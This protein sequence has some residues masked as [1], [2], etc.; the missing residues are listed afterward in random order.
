MRKAWLSYPERRAVNLG[1]SY[2]ALRERAS[3]FLARVRLHVAEFADL[4]T[5]F[6]PAWE[7]YHRY[8]TLDGARRQPTHRERANA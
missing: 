5:D 6:G 3:Q 4:L 8:H 2:S 1:V 7:R